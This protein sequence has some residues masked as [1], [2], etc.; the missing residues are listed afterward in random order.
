MSALTAHAKNLGVDPLSV[1]YDYSTNVKE[2]L[3]YIFSK[4]LRDTTNNFVHW[5]TDEIYVLG[6]ALMA[7]TSIESPDAI[8]N[9][10]GSAVDGMTHKQ[11]AQEVVNFIFEA[12]FETGT[13]IGLW[14]YSHPGSFGD[15]SVS[16][17]VTLGLMYAKDHFNIPIPQ[18]LLII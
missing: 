5:G 2:A 4:A 15:M 3:D 9:V 14:E 10:A 17:W 8:V 1:D 18:A 12:Q 7:I 16:G 11:V 13:M 6:P